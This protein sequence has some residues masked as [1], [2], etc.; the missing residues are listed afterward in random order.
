MKFYQR[1]LAELHNL[2]YTGHV[3]KAIPGVLAL[4]RWAGIRSGVVLDLGCGGGQLSSRLQRAGYKAIGIDRS[5]E[6]VRLARKR[7]PKAKFLCGSVS[8][9]RMPQCAAAVAIGEVFNYLPTP[10]SVK[11]ALSSV[12]RALAPGGILVFD[13]KEPLAGPETK[14]RSL[15]RWGKDWAIFVEVEEQPRRGRLTRKIVTFR[16]I[17]KG[18]RRSDE[19]HRQ[20]LYRGEDIARMLRD[21]GFATKISPSYGRFRLLPDRKVLVARKPAQPHPRKPRMPGPPA[22]LAR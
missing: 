8:Q 22:K 16:K 12:T 6:M 15:A 21:L 19:I 9:L 2:Y 20:V 17:G 14:N 3:Q 1:D 4:L 13:I 11:R 7:V 18:Y 5:M 10:A